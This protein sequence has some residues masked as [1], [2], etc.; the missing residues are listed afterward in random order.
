MKV[1][2]VAIIEMVLGALVIGASLVCTYAYSVAILG[3][4]VILFGIPLLVK[5]KK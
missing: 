5:P 3:A 2:T 1:S 4:L